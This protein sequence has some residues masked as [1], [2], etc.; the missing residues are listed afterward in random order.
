MYA[1]VRVKIL[2][3][4]TIN[5][6]HMQIKLLLLHCLVSALAATAA[7]ASDGK[8]VA[9]LTAVILVVVLALLLHWLLL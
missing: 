8:L 9:E 1:Q 7:V 4:Y 3:Y 6:K 2:C 5:V